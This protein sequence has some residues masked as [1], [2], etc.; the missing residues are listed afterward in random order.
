MNVSNFTVWRT[1][2]GDNRKKVL[3]LTLL[4]QATFAKL[5]VLASPTPVGEFS[6]DSMLEHLTGHFCPKTIE[7]AERFKFFKQSQHEDESATDF[8]AELR[9]LAKTCNFA[10]YLE[11]AISDQFICGL[12]D[13]KFQQEL[14]CQTNLTAD[15]AL[16]RAQGME[17]VAKE[18]E[19]MQTG[20]PEQSEG[21]T[22][23]VASKAVCYRCGGQGHLASTCRF[24]NTK[25]HFCQ[26]LGH[27]AR[28]C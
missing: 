4:G 11:T 26:N 1:G 18:S 3:F 21:S 10:T 23:L 27:V 2:E 5:K 8:I 19:S 17:E 13:P 22:N 14:L 25:C 28:V 6:M 20:K 7:I 9:A 16:Q 24:R 15:L 12:N